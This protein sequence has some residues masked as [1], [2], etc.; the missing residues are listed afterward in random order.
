VHLEPVFYTIQGVH[1]FQSLTT[2]CIIF[3]IWFILLLFLILKGNQTEQVFAL[4]AFG[5]I[6]LG[7]WVLK[8]PY[9]GTSDSIFNFGHVAYIEKTGHIIFNHPNLVYFEFPVLHIEGATV[10][11]ICGISVTTMSVL[12][13]MFNSLLFVISLY[14]LFQSLL[15]NSLQL[16]PA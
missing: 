9:G 16:S 7:F 12:F 8:T 3:I 11:E 2:F 4:C 6:F 1:I 10:S 5:L 13:L 15:K 14:L